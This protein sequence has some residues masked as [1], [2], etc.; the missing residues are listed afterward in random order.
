MFG[1]ILGGLIGLGLRLII[2]KSHSRVGLARPASKVELASR[3][4]LLYFMLPVWIV[5]GFLDYI[6]HRKTNIET[7]AGTR[8]S[9]SHLLMHAEEG[10][11]VTMA[12]LFEVNAGMLALMIAGFIAHTLTAWYDVAFA[13]NRRDMPPT[14]QHIHAWLEV[15]PFANLSFAIVLHW[16][17][18]KALFG[19]G[20]ER[21]RFALR[22]RKPMLPPSYLAGLFSAIGAFIVIPFAEEFVR[23]R[24]AERLGLT[25]EDT[26]IWLKEREVLEP[27]RV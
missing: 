3:R 4:Y 15:L 9:L 16:D 26:P 5:P 17:Q 8:E 10:I 13:A 14:E 6:W 19:L 23:C 27:E 2:P 18:F 1:W 25:G 12:L 7:T 22:W 24:R 21:P 11:P 20:S